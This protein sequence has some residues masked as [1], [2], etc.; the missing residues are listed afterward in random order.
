L[1]RHESCPIV[2][3]CQLARRAAILLRINGGFGRVSIECTG[4]VIHCRR[5]PGGWIAGIEFESPLTGEQIESLQALAR[6]A[7]P[8]RNH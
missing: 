6:P 1:T 8:L 4:Q 5:S 7:F 2:M 3:P